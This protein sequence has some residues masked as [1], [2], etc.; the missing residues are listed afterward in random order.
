LI[1]NIDEVNDM[2]IPKIYPETT[3]FN[4]YFDV[5][6]GFAHT[7]TVALFDEIASGK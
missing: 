3:L 5:E 6:R 7:D 4:Y 1:I 2:R